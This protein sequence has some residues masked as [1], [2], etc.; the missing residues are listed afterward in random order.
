MNMSRLRRDFE[1]MWDAMSPELKTM[2]GRSYIDKHVEGCEQAIPQACFNLMLVVNDIKHALF[3]AKPR[4]RYLIAGGNKWYDIYRW[5]T[6]LVAYLPTWL[7]D[8]WL[9]ND[10]TDFKTAQELQ[11]NQGAAKLSNE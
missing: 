11:Q 10:V 8:R 9:L 7:M 3:S 4:V 5:R 1:E 6:H 2:Y